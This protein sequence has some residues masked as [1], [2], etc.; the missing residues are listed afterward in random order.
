MKE[1]LLVAITNTM[2]MDG[3]N[4]TD[5]DNLNPQSLNYSGGEMDEDLYN[6]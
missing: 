5:Q 6:Y 2:S 4:Q 1:K 3:D